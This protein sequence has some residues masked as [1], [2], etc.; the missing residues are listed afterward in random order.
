MHKNSSNAYS[1]QRC[2]KQK[3]LHVILHTRYDTINSSNPYLQLGTLVQLSHV[4]P[5]L[6]QTCCLQTARHTIVQAIGHTSA[7]SD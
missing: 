2:I 7:M 3:S 5:R 6:L 4:A 1:P